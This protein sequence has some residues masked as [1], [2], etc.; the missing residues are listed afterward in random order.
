MTANQRNMLE[1]ALIHCRLDSAL[2][3]DSWGNILKESTKPDEVFFEIAADVVSYQTKS[4]DEL[5]AEAFR[6]SNLEEWIGSS[7]SSAAEM[8]ANFEKAPVFETFKAL[9]EYVSA[10]ID[11]GEFATQTSLELVLWQIRKR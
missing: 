7:A 10:E 2:Q 6:T 8:I 3:G 11:G 9:K 5:L 4:D 1:L